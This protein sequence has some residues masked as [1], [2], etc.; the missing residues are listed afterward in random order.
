MAAIFKRFRRLANLFAIGSDGTTYVWGG[1]NVSGPH[2]I[3]STIDYSSITISGANLSKTSSV[4]IDL[5]GDGTPSDDVLCSDLVVSSTRLTC[6]IPDTT[7]DGD[8]QP[9]EYRIGVVIDGQVLLFDLKFTY[10]RQQSD[11]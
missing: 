11:H 1:D 9:G 10:A 4:F 7:A 8:I 3:T 2:D 6:N 5:S